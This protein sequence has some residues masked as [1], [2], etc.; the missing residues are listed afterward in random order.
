MLRVNPF[1]GKCIDGKKTTATGITI[2]PPCMSTLAYGKYI[3]KP[4]A[5][6]IKQEARV[7]S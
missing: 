1:F 4:F 5:R 3:V 2:P 7:Q 6:E